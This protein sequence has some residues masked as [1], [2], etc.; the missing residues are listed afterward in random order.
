MPATRAESTARRPAAA[1]VRRFGRWLAPL[2]IAALVAV[3]GTWPLA[4]VALGPVEAV[5]THP[6]IGDGPHAAGHV[7]AWG[8][9]SAAG[10][11]GPFREP[12]VGPGGGAYLGVGEHGALWRVA[13]APLT[14]ALGPHRAAALST[15]LLLAAAGALAYRA[16]R[17]L[18]TGR[19]PGVAG[20][21]AFVASPALLERGLVA[22]AGLAS[23]LVPAAAL[24]AAALVRLRSPV[25]AAIALGG[26]GAAASAVG[27]GTFVAVALA[28]L[29][30]AWLARSGAPRVPGGSTVVALGLA[31][32]A[33]TAT[34]AALFV[35]GARADARAAEPTAIEG[36]APSH[37]V[38]PLAASVTRLR[39]LA[40]PSPFHPV[41][42]RWAGPGT[43]VAG[44]PAPAVGLATLALAALVVLRVRRWRLPAFAAL[45][46]T[47]AAVL[48]NHA[49]VEAAL[50]PVGILGLCLVAARGCEAAGR[51]PAAALA[52]LLLLDA[53]VAPWPLER[54]EP[55]AS[56]E[57][58]ATSPVPGSVLDLPLRSGS[59]VALSRQ[60]V[61]GRRTP[62]PA[63][64]ERA[65]AL[66]GDLVSRAPTMGRLV[67]GEPPLDSDQLAA[68]FEWIGV[69]HVQ[70]EI[71]TLSDPILD[72][73]DRM[74]GWER[75]P[76]DGVLHWWYRTRGLWSLRTDADAAR[77]ADRA[78]RR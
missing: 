74:P 49:A 21:I 32:A 8:L 61:H 77:G 47:A 39:P 23:P 16:A 43:I 66:L 2:L 1:P 17:A 68:E 78:R 22:H 38:D 52:G 59:Q 30:G 56:L 72:A 55:S 33:S 62:V 48:V 67:L 6:L 57:R 63:Y 26:A 64:P 25:L 35:D 46:T 36:A 42:R 45:L 70:V 75:A 9:W 12:R 65:G 7:Q 40:G 69:G 27:A 31:L 5:P 3:A 24:A 58:L 29:A 76:D 54:W 11:A 73:L 51:V 20:A 37:S 4:R 60:T 13:A 10:A 19:L 14:R 28:A 44:K 50:L 15:L 71:G 41:I 18:G 34:T 53:V